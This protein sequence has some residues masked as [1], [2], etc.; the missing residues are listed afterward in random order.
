MNLGYEDLAATASVVGDTVL[1]SGQVRCP[2]EANN[3]AA[4][5]SFT[6]PDVSV[7]NLTID[8]ASVY[9]SPTTG[10][11]TL[12]IGSCWMNYGTLSGSDNFVFSG[13]LTLGSF[14]TLVGAAGSAA[15]AYGGIEFG[16]LYLPY[17][18]TLDGRTLNNHAT[19]TFDSGGVTFLD[20]ATF[21]NLDGATF[22]DRATSFGHG[23]AAGTGGGAFNNN[24]SYVDS[25]NYVSSIGV[26]FINTGTVDVQAGTLSLGNATNSGTVTVSSGTTLGVGSYTQTAGAHRAQRRHDQWWL[27]QCQRRCAFGLRHDQRLRRQLPA[28]SSPGVPASQAF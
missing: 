20:G 18:Q 22:L 19:A 26:P 5:G 3:T 2:F 4:G 21:N 12:D 28:W 24:G 7:G 27:R 6:N 13:P 8:N 10:P 1:I 14:S 23:I 16:G 25:G 9:F 17:P 11:Q 15:D